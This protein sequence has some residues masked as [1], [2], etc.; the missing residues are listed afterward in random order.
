MT[1]R[2]ATSADDT[3]A[4]NTS[5][6]QLTTDEPNVNATFREFIAV[7]VVGSQPK[8]NSRKRKVGHACVLTQSPYKKELIQSKQLKIDSQERKEKRIKKKL[9]NEIA[10]QIQ[11]KQDKIANGANESQCSLKKTTKRKSRKSLQGKTKNR[12]NVKIEKK[13]KKNVT[14]NTATANDSDCECL[15]CGG[16]YSESAEDFIQCQG[17]CELWA[18]AGCADVDTHGQYIC[19]H[20]A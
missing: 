14:K 1:D 15:Y 17:N 13:Q 2:E 3:S 12:T 16:L 10:R 9:E 5:A 11:L 6:V 18:H 7:P 19:E 4:V 20:C 8:P